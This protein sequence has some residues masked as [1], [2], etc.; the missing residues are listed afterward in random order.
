[1]SLLNKLLIDMAK[2][3]ICRKD[4]LIVQDIDGVCIPLVKNPMER[5]I[6]VNYLNAAD[7]LKGHFYVLTNGEH[8]GE[9]GVNKIVEKAFNLNGHNSK[10]IYYMP[11][12]AAGGVEFQDREGTIDYMGVMKEEIDFLS[13]IPLLMIDH[14]KLGLEELVPGKTG[15]E[16]EAYAKSSV[17]N[18]ILSPTINLNFLFSLA[19]DNITFRRDLQSLIDKITKSLL[20]YSIKRG[21]EDS[22]Y[23]HIAPNL[24]K[25]SE[26]E[27]IKYASED[28]IGTTDIQFMIK[29]AIKEAG[30]LVLLNKYLSKK[31]GRFPFGENFNSRVAPQTID[32]LLKLCREKIEINEMPM[33]I[34]VG[35]TVTSNKSLSGTEYLR[36]G[37]DRGFLT[38]I[39]ELGK[40]FKQE[41]KVILVDSSD[42]EV[43]RPS[44]KNNSLMG[45]SDSQDPLKFNA[46]MDQG[47]KQYIEWF[48]LLASMKST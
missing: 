43:D 15:K 8:G 32:G 18:T 20:S 6:E 11:G 25:S 22:F 27:I 17:I 40:Q 46:V 42:G 34:G 10:K 30:L 31:M 3:I 41:N 23:L 12:L 39:Q 38:L 7:N 45:V 13:E 2:A 28:D 21:F 29:G 4:F 14:L 37:S 5:R 1:M 9:R 48:K 26:G 35:D 33:L 47:H 36:G 44:L 16:I 19:Q 24:G